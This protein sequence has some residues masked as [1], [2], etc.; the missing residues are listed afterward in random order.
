MFIYR[1]GNAAFA[2]EAYQEA[3]SVSLKVDEIH[4]LT[5]MLHEH[6]MVVDITY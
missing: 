5:S 1:D 6:C 3:L 4:T 2:S